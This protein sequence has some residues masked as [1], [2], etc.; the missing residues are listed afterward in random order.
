M[1]R[2]AAVGDA[3]FAA[4]FRVSERRA[5]ASF[6][7]SAPGTAYI[8]R[9]ARVAELVD[10]GD[11]KSPG[12]RGLAGSSPALG[13]HGSILGSFDSRRA[14]GYLTVSRFRVAERRHAVALPGPC[15][16]SSFFR[17]RRCTNC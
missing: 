13:I 16:A 15:G 2:R 10:A 17:P 7:E 5:S 14:A 8:A 11:S 9:P 1:G 3:E 12:P 4:A 6:V